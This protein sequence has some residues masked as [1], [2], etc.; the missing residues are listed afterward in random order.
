MKRGR[1]YLL[2]RHLSNTGSRAVTRSVRM[3]QS[4]HNI[5][6]CTSGS[7]VVHIVREIVDVEE[8]IHKVAADSQLVVSSVRIASR[9][10]L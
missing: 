3:I 6:S 8:I 5:I 2:A 1:I 7:F 4:S 9:S 10:Q